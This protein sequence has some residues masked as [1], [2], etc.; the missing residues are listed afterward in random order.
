MITLHPDLRHL[1]SDAYAIGLQA[2]ADLDLAT[3]LLMALLQRHD[4]PVDSTAARA[5]GDAT[6]CGMQAACGNG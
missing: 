3:T 2:A 5:L 4:I 6:T 1:A